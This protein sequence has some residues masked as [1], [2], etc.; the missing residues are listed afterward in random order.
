MTDPDGTSSLNR[1][2]QAPS[3][4]SALWD[5][6]NWLRDQIKYTDGSE[7]KTPNGALDAARRQLHQILEEH[8]IKLE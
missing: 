1:A 3:M 5:I 6:D 4:I 7:F 2:L 8:N